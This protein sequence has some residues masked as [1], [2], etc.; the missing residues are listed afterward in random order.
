[1]PA[2]FENDKNT[3]VNLKMMYSAGNEIQNNEKYKKLY[4]A[5]NIMMAELS[6]HGHI[7]T[8]DKQVTDVMDVLHEIDGGV[9]KQLE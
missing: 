4:H 5:V 1:M 2:L 8:R 7:R 9:Y 6:S 3:K